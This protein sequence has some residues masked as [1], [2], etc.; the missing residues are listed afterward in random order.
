MQRVVGQSNLPVI[1]EALLDIFAVR[2]SSRKRIVSI[3]LIVM[4]HELSVSIISA[5]LD[6]SVLYYTVL[7]CTV[8]NY[9]LETSILESRLKPDSLILNWA[10]ATRQLH[11]QS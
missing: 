1:S 2:L 5:R 4:S 6:Y 11:Y 9:I 3:V 7:Y 8:L 10:A